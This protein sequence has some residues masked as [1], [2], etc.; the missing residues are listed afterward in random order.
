VREVSFDPDNGWIYADYGFRG[1][2]VFGIRWNERG[3]WLLFAQSNLDK[4]VV[5]ASLAY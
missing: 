3:C 1:Q 4:M 2:I 5:N